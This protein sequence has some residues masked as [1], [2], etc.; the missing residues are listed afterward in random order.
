MHKT[1]IINILKS[2]DINIIDTAEN[3]FNKSED[4]LSYFPSR[5]NGH[6]NE[7]GYYNV[8]SYIYKALNL[9]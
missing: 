6:Y 9:N 5:K 3:V 1:D 7:K 8:S 4:P 2:N